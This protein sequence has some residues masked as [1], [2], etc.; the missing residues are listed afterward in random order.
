MERIYLAANGGIAMPFSSPLSCDTNT[1][2]YLITRTAANLSIF[3]S[4]Y[5]GLQAKG[6]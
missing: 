2:L 1:T 3:I 4:G 5:T 6:T